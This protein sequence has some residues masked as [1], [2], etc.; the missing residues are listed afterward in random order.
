M[1][2]GKEAGGFF[3]A[4]WFYFFQMTLEELEPVKA[5]SKE[6][7]FFWEENRGEMQQ[8]QQKCT[9]IPQTWAFSKEL[10]LS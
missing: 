1:Q 6:Q 10:W 4:F 9:R 8:Q 2:P 3:L 5:L 7:G